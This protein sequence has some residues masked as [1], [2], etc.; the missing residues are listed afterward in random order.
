MDTLRSYFTKM[1]ILN[2]GSK[3]WKFS[4][5]GS[6]GKGGGSNSKK[7]CRSKSQNDAALA[8]SV[9][10]GNDY[11][12]KANGGVSGQESIRSPP[13]KPPRKDQVFV[14]DFRKFKGLNFGVVLDVLPNTCPFNNS[15]D[16]VLGDTGVHDSNE[17]ITSKTIAPVVVIKI[18]KGSLADK[19][20]R[21]KVN[22]EIVDINGI[23]LIGETCNSVR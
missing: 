3:T 21:I 8:E 9:R 6:L 22:D 18:Q 7:Y 1:K 11:S 20:G 2:Q 10:S 12:E 4:R 17:D 19:D 13:T 16:R 5:K 15:V 23:P 14:V